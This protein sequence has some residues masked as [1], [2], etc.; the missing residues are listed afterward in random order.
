MFPD[1]PDMQFQPAQGLL[2][3][4]EHTRATLT[5]TLD[6]YTTSR[7]RNMPPDQLEA[8]KLFHENSDL[9]VVNTDKGL[10]PAVDYTYR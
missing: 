4:L 6:S 10:G 7:Q 3:F 1:S 5:E 9:L 8:L 2:S